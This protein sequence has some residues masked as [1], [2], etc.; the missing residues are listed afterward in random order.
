MP[1]CLALASWVDATN[2]EMILVCVAPPKVARANSVVCHHAAMPQT[3]LPKETAIVNQAQLGLWFVYTLEKL[4]LSSCFLKHFF[5]FSE[6]YELN[7]CIHII[8][9]HIP[10]CN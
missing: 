5:V 6:I 3:I 2:I 10:H 4:A 7:E 9:G 8:G 1:P